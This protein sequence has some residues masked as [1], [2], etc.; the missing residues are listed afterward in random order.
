LKA[1]LFGFVIALTTSYQGLAQPLRL[2]DVA[3]AST[4]A[5]VASVAA[6]VL[7]DALF[8][9]IYLVM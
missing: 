8:I 1:L 6:C 5:V 7:L 2:E 4:R 3:G 9:V